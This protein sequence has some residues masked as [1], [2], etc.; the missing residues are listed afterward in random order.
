M[1]ADD[2][3]LALGDVDD[4]LLTEAE[5]LTERPAKHR[6]FLRPLIAAAAAVLL[7]LTATAAFFGVSVRYRTNTLAG[8]A[9]TIPEHGVFIEPRYQTAEIRFS[10]ETKQVQNEALS[11]CLTAAWEQ[12]PYAHSTFTGA[13]LTE[14]NG[15][16]RSFASLQAV[17]DF[18][19]LPL[20]TTEALS[21]VDGPYYVR[22]LISDSAQAAMEYADTGRLQ[23]TALVIESA[24]R[25]QSTVRP[26]NLTVLIAL[27]DALPKG[28]GTQY[29]TV[30]EEEGALF[31]SRARSSGG[32]E[33]LL[34]ETERTENHLGTGGIYWCSDGIGYSA[35][36]EVAPNMPERVPD[37]L[38]PL[39]AELK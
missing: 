15:T 28:F 26:G 2:V 24:L 33:M 11:E 19:G 30:I 29:L 20:N 35:S 13:V 22:M 21:A 4:A 31:E 36:A 32:T 34:L 27:S 39:L 17:G 25:L 5:C 3:L 18:L 23:P 1:K 14:A 6:R 16:R 8:I 38:M 37:V 10:L 9:V 12:W 7:T